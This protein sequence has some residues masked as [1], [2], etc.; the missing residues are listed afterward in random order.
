[1][2]TIWFYYVKVKIIKSNICVLTDKSIYDENQNGLTMGK[3]KRQ[4]GRNAQKTSR[5]LTLCAGRGMG[6]W[7]CYVWC[8][9]Y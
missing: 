9:F 1:M 3:N 8:V 4:V 7:L 5:M 2:Y 6:G